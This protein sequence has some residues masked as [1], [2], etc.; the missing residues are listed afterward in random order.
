LVFNTKGGSIVFYKFILSYVLSYVV[1]AAELEILIKCFDVNPY[2][3]QA[4]CVLHGVLISWLL[5]N[6]WVYKSE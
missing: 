1:N 2:L 4:L 5:M 6:Y 3:A